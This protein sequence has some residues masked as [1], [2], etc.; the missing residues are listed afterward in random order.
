MKKLILIAGLAVLSAGWSGTALAGN[1]S[2]CG[3]GSLI[4]QGQS[5]VAPNVLAIT[6]NGTFWNATFG[7]S[8][9]SAGCQKDGVVLNEH[10]RDMYA[11]TNLRQL[12]NEMARGQGEYLDGLA[13]LM[14][15][16]EANLGAFRA[17]SQAS[18]PVLLEAEDSAGFLAA[19]DREMA[20]DPVLARYVTVTP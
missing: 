10:E 1:S 3:A 20:A 18:L 16:G 17:F 12:K 7:M 13:S 4:F 19:L 11:A 15:V 6:T 14:G 8:T 2:G 5:G 9:G